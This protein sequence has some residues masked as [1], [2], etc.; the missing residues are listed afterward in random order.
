MN[1]QINSETLYKF[2]HS[3]VVADW[4]KKSGLTYQN[5]MGG[6]LR[7]RQHEI[8]DVIA[9]FRSIIAIRIACARLFEKTHSGYLNA[10]TEN[11]SATWPLLKVLFRTAPTWNESESHSLSIDAIEEM[12]N[13]ANYEEIESKIVDLGSQIRFAHE[14]SSMINEIAC[15][16][17]ERS[18]SEFTPQDVAR[19]MGRLA[20]IE[21][22]CVDVYCDYG[23]GLYLGNCINHANRIR[24]VGDEVCSNVNNPQHIFPKGL[25]NVYQ[26]AKY[27]FDREAVFEKMLTELEW[28]TRDEN[29]KKSKSLIVNAAEYQ[30]P[31]YER[32]ELEQNTY[33]SLDHLLNAGY[34][35]IIVLVQNTYLTGG[36]GIASSQKIFKYCISKGLTGVIQLPMGVIGA[37]H[38]AY[39]I[40]EF[41]PGNQQGKVDF[42]IMNHGDE[43]DPSRLCQKAKRGFG[44]P[45]RKVELNLH[46]ITRDGQM[47][48]AS[49]KI[50]SVSDVL[51][52]GAPIRG[53]SKRHLQL[54]SFEANRFIDRMDFQEL[55]PK[56]QFG[57]LS[58]LVEIYRVQHM[59]QARPEEGIEYIELGGVNIGKLGNIEGGDKKY[60]YESSED[61]LNKASLKK[62]DLFLCIRG[63][64]G[65]V[66]I[67][68]ENPKII[69]APNQ[70]FVKLTFK[71]KANTEGITP[72]LLFW[73]LNSNFCKKYLSSRAVSVGVPRLS[74]QDV[75]EL[76][77]PIGP[78]KELFIEAEKY[79]SWSQEVEYYLIHEEKAGFLSGQAFKS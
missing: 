8:E 47:P 63:S 69:T 17:F 74:I 9:A 79:R 35:K 29:N 51:N 36:R 48:Q 26:S 56:F 23:V 20:G 5:W 18:G 12:I 60:I 66:G 57:V 33:D 43:K 3:K 76:Q 34:K 61:R 27:I 58:D 41:E 64:I 4:K 7:S 14:A 45:L 67:M 2:F 77:I 37:S 30:L 28:A 73:W 46:N 1:K 39:S 21:D 62:G 25:K 32:L 72:E 55:L 15:Q 52:Q 24:L 65:I 71:K 78:A 50:V 16:G 13:L 68:V 22:E 38:E 42:R 54:V 10:R 44:L 70:S 75:L 53:R 40:L 49:R 59:Q 6:K 11:T 19:F 31:F